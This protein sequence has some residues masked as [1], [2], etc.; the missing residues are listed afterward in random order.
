MILLQFVKSFFFLAWRRYF[1]HRVSFL[2]ICNDFSF[3]LQKNNRTR[4]SSS[5]GADD[6]RLHTA[7]VR[8][9]VKLSSLSCML[10]KFIHLTFPTS[11][12]LIYNNGKHEINAI[13]KP[14]MLTEIRPF[15]D[16]TDFHFIWGLRSQFQFWPM[17]IFFYPRKNYHNS[18][19]NVYV[20]INNNDNNNTF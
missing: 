14:D 9:C 15:L 13:I 19:I 20:S 12:S 3:F 5:P 18:F 16:E 1:T 7:K 8:R 11:N 6:S 10:L 4:Q 2:F 17:Q